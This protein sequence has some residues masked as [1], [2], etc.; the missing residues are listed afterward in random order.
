MPC[1]DVFVQDVPA[2]LLRK[3]LRLACYMDPTRTA[4]LDES[5]AVRVNYETYFFAGEGVPA[6]L[7]PH[8]SVPVRCAAGAETRL[9]DLD[10]AHSPGWSIGQ[11]CL[12][13]G[14]L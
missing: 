9:C 4:M 14:C 8:W 10:K 13:C 7:A 11:H 5:H 3:G 2:A 1:P 12:T 6:E